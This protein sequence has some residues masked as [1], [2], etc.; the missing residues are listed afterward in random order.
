MSL[1]LL[2]G[3]YIT[4]KVGSAGPKGYASQAL[5]RGVVETP[6]TPKATARSD[7]PKGRV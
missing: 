2:F 5:P 6:P 4:V 7:V 1:L 3:G